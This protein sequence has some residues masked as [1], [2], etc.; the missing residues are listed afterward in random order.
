MVTLTNKT[1]RHVELEDTDGKFLVINSKA[2]SA[3]LDEKKFTPRTLRLI[4]D[5]SL[6]KKEIVA[7]SASKEVKTSKDKVSANDNKKSTKTK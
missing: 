7:K 5:G 1:N 4:K 3:P 2:V 6:L